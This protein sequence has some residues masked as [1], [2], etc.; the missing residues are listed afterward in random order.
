MADD[1]SG[2]K[3]PKCLQISQNNEICEYCGAIFSK[4]REREYAGEF[5]VA[6]ASRPV[7]Q[8]PTG[9]TSRVLFLVVIFV[10]VAAGVVA[11][12]WMWKN[13]TPQTIDDLITAHR[14]VTKR[15]RQVIA[16][17]IEAHKSL[18]EHKKLYIEVLDLAASVSKF[19]EKKHL[20]DDLK[21]Q[22]E[23]LN[24]ANSRLAE[25]LNMSPEDFVAAAAKMNYADPFAEVDEKLNIAQNPELARRASNPLLQALDILRIRAVP[26]PKKD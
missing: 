7:E 26:S 10:I 18:P 21:I 19:A 20:T 4:V 3:C 6:E 8:Q 25:L 11:G 13:M 5:F 24:D 23:A 1:Y 14:K 12:L 17:E 9:S 22:I 16:D 15:A 2:T